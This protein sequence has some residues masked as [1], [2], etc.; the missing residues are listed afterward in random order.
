MSTNPVPLPC[1]QS[2]SPG[3]LLPRLL[4]GVVVAYAALL[5]TTF[6][7]GHWLIGADGQA[8]ATD[9]IAFWAAG[10]LVLQ[11][12]ASLA[13]DWHVHKSA[14][15]A[16][17]GATFSGFFSWQYPPTLLLLTPMFALVPYATA[18]LG[19]MVLTGAAFA[20]TI[21]SIVQSRLAL[22][23]AVAWPAVFWNVVVGQT[24][25]LTAALL[26]GGTLF[27]PRHPLLAG[28]L[29]GLLTYKPQFGL[30]IPIALVAGGC[31]RAVGSAMATA[32]LLAAVTTGA[33]GIEIW[34]A[35]WA[36]IRSINSTLLLEG[37]AGFAEMQSFY[38][39]LRAAGSG[40]E[41]AIT[42]HVVLVAVLATGLVTI[43]RS[44]CSFDIKAAALTVSTVLASPYAF[45][46]D[47]VALVVPLAFLAR[48]GF[49][50][51]EY[52]VIAVAGIL[53][54]W[55]PSHVLPTGLI[56]GLLVLALTVARLKQ[57]I[58]G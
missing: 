4:F 53:V 5:G 54:G 35:F 24:G 10:K 26:G 16:A 34:S 12:N 1:L 13:Y 50:R 29:F 3:W 46:Y 25:F 28:I 9:F 18:L 33:F 20:I 52:L 8:R 45:I 41:V 40:K 6:F 19:W 15:T 36:G 17:S 31:W 23:A 11:G 55:G 38:A 14:A 58:R 47:L 39:F 56:S 49:S 32:I 43:W 30:L 37:G 22:L 42:A 21:K 2:G 51:R 57:Q 27:L 48:T 44:R 7:N